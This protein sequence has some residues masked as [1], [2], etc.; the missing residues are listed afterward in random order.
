[1]HTIFGSF[2]PP[3]APAARGGG[4]GGSRGGGG[5]PARVCSVGLGWGRSDIPLRLSGGVQPPAISPPLPQTVKMEGPGSLPSPFE[6]W[7]RGSLVFANVIPR[8]TFLKSPLPQIGGCLSR[9]S[10]PS[11]NINVGR[12]SLGFGSVS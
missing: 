7:E 5:G 11:W 9:V 3:G 6:C 12:G 4:G 2:L 1:V 10:T 8:S